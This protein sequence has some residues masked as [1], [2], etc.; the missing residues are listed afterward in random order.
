M[1]NKDVREYAKK[2]GVMLWQ[3]AYELGMTDGT[4]SRKLRRELPDA[5]KEKIRQIIARLREA[6]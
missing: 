3:I 1:K 5:E 6:S 4:F 2:A